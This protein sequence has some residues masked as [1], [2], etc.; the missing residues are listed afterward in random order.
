[1]ARSSWT[2]TRCFSSF[3]GGSRSGSGIA[4]RVKPPTEGVQRP[5][6]RVAGHGLYTPLT[7]VNHELLQIDFRDQRGV[8]VVV[9]GFSGRGNT[10]SKPSRRT[11]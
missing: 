3:W 6:P 11:A 1:M 9:D 2:G 8:M 4:L 7:E 5:H 10:P